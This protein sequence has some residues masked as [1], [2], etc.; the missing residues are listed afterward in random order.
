VKLKDQPGQS[1]FDALTRTTIR[2][3][4]SGA[5]DLYVRALRLPWSR[6]FMFAALGFLAL[7]ALFGALYMIGDGAIAGARP[8]SFE[9][10][11]FFSVQTLA[12]IGYG[13]MAPATTYGHVLVTLEAMVGLFGVGM[14]AALAFARLS[15]P[16]ARIRFSA[17]AVICDFDGAP[18]LMLRAA[19]E[20]GNSIIQARVQVSLLRPETTREGG[21]MRRFYDLKLARAETPIFSLSWLIMHPITEDSP[22]FGITAERLAAG[23]FALLVSITGIDESLAQSVN[24]RQSYFNTDVRLN[25]RFRDML[26]VSGDGARIVDLRRIDEVEPA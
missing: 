24:A 12:T 18:T 10:H 1:R 16:T 25:H 15:L 5:G 17:V 6:F 8:G 13:G 3:N 19:N 14:V 26:E 9:D 2:T 11:F 22:L 23:E 4:E 20:R 21:M 7:N